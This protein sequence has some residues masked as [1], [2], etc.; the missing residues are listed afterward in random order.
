MAEAVRSLSTVPRLTLA[1]EDEGYGDLLPGAL[2]LEVDLVNRGIRLCEALL[3]LV[4]GEVSPLAEACA[5]DLGCEIQSSDGRDSGDPSSIIPR[6][7]LT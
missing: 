7:L 1:G 5:E 2:G 3:E 4:R 6:L